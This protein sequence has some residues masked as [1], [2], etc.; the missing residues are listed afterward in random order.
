MESMDT[1]DEDIN[2]LSL[3][4]E[5]MEVDQAVNISMK[6]ASDLM[7]EKVMEKERLHEEKDQLFKIEKAKADLEKR[8]VEEEKLEQFK[9]MNKKRK[10]IFKLQR[11]I[12]NKK[13]IKGES[14][15]VK[16]MQQ[17]IKIP[18]NKSIPDN[19]KHLLREGDILYVVP[20]D[21]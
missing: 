10:Q 20:G 1:E 21:G 16:N 4:L 14:F 6:E 8:L 9:S 18:N 5:E 17:K 12:S 3:K 15:K 7:D 19:C 2:D 13:I 11:K